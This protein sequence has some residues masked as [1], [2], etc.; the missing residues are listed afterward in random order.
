[1]YI[2]ELNRELTGEEF[3]TDHAHGNYVKICQTIKCNAATVSLRGEDRTY[4]WIERK[5]FT[6]VR[7]YAGL[8][9]QQF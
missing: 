2:P 3:F 4:L 1:M 6:V 7:V 9:M 8:V 5:M